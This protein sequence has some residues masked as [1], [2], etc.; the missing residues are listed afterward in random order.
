MNK[1]TDIEAALVLCQLDR[2][3]D[4][5]AARR[6]CAAIYNRA[7]A[8]IPRIRLPEERGERVWYRYALALAPQHMAEARSRLGEAGIMA[9]RPIEPWLDA[10]LLAEYPVAQRAFDTLLSLPLYPTLS[11][12]EQD[13]VITNLTSLA[14]Q[15]KTGY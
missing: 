12:A 5:L 4:M 13:H 7:F 9:C 10:A 8:G 2:L 14:A 6:A 3:C 1:M 15:W 11:G